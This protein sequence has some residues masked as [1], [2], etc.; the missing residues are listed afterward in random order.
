M[1][2]QARAWVVVSRPDRLPV[3]IAAAQ[4]LRDQYPDG[5]HLLREESK[6]WDHAEW[7]PYATQ[8]AAVHAFARVATCRGIRD[9]LRLYRQ[10]LDRRRAIQKLPI[11]SCRDVLVCLG[12]ILT[13]SNVAASAHPN[14]TKILC[15]S[16]KVYRDLMRAGDRARYRFTTASWFQNRIV[17]PMAGINRTLRY[18]PRINPGGD[19]VRLERMESD[20]EK[21]YNAIVVMSNSGEI[22]FPNVVSARFPSIA[23]LRGLPEISGKN[24]SKSRRRVLFFGTPFLLIHNLP[25]SLYVQHLEHCL[26]YLR[27][28]FPDHY[29]IYR[30]HPNETTEARQ[31][32]MRGFEVEDDRE[33]AELYFLRNYESIAAVF[34]VS[35]TVSRTALN[36]GL[37][38]YAMYP[39]FPFSEQQS[40][41]FAEVMGDVPSEFNIRS[42][43][44]PVAQYQPITDMTGHA[45]GDALRMASE[46]L[47]MPAHP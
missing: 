5:V 28:N 3:A 29:L 38:G 22:S 21:I 39:L 13:I 10:S 47:A 42:L 46:R 19:G 32:D 24:A 4:A 45:F 6:W 37:N 44:S 1:K 2:D 7:Q 27:I 34:S 8:F 43:H 20:P 12:G 17:E 40:Q 14:V 36:N 33:A 25:P 9:L 18:K 41:F 11:D 30:P 16:A 35:S 26:D 31:V 15:V 23:E